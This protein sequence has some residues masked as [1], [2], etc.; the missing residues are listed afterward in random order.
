MTYADLH[1]LTKPR[2][3]RRDARVDLFLGQASKFCDLA[4]VKA[5]QKIQLKNL[6]F[7][8]WPMPDIMLENL[9]E[10]LTRSCHVRRQNSLIRD[11]V[12]R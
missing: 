7:I 1:E 4:S 5:D 12:L 3:D 2:L 8:D 6:L 9:Q 10:F 11:T